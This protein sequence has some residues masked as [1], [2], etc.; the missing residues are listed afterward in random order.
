MRSKNKIFICYASEDEIHKNNLDKHL[1]GLKRQGIIESYDSTKIHAG[2]NWNESIKL[3]LEQANII[4][5]LLSADL[6]ANDLIH[7]LQIQEALKKAEKKDIILIPIIIR[8]VAYRGLGIEKYNTLPLNKKAVIE[9]ENQDSAYEHITLEIKKV[10]QKTKEENGI[11]HNKKQRYNVKPNT[12]KYLIFFF[13]LIVLIFGLLKYMQNS[14]N[15]PKSSKLEKHTFTYY[16]F[17]GN[18]EN[19][20]GKPLKDVSINIKQIN[21]SN[22]LTNSKGHFTIEVK[23]PITNFLEFGLSKHGYKSESITVDFDKNKKIQNIGRLQLARDKSIISNDPKYI[24][25]TAKE[26]GNIAHNIEGVKVTYKTEKYFTNNMGKTNVLISDIE[27]LEGSKIINFHFSKVGYEDKGPIPYLFQRNNPS[28]V[29]D[30]RRIEVIPNTTENG[31]TLHHDIASILLGQ[32]KSKEFNGFESLNMSGLNDSSLT[33]IVNNSKSVVKKGNPHIKE[34]DFEKGE[35][36]VDYIMI[37]LDPF[38]KDIDDIYNSI[39][40]PRKLIISLNRNNDTVDFN[41][42]NSYTFS[43]D[44]IKFKNDDS[45]YFNVIGSSQVSGYINNPEEYEYHG[46]YSNRKIEIYFKHHIGENNKQLVYKGSEL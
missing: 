36:Y 32:E 23:H 42:E 4:L 24:E 25:I 39:K 29:V 28:L 8:P 17:E 18:V 30:L 21:H 16:T 37:M 19:K 2:K 9:W 7:D 20:I 1:S 43:C 41:L 3:Y 38:I 35:K 34:D 27:Q 22:I 11:N 45:I 10:L 6:L 5:L 40:T 26:K 44:I 33:Q 13:I 46:K 31:E 14:N 15:P 12:L